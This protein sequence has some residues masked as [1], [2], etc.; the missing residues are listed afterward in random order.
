LRSST[1]FYRGAL[2]DAERGEGSF[3]IALA[4]LTWLAENDF[5]IAIAGRQIL[6]EDDTEARQSYGALTA[7]LGLKLDPSDPK[8]LVLFPEMVANDDPPE[9]T[10]DCWDILN[11]NPAD[12]MCAD[13]R[14]I[15]KRKG[16]ETATVTAC[17]LLA[18]DA[19]FELGETLE[20][21]TSAPVHLNH[22]WCAT[23]CVL[24]GGSCSA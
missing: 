7:R 22:A 8:Q 4:G 2:H 14:M 15:I 11:K 13:Q 21:A 9:I 1:L 23:F 18:Y 10:T 12:I 17:T 20:A 16:A 19:E 6:T 5:T 3:D 24:G